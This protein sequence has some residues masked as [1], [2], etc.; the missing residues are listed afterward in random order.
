MTKRTEITIETDQVLVIRRRR[1]VLRTWCAACAEKVEMV[2]ADEAA[3]AA[4]VDLGTIHYWVK[5]CNVHFRETPE[6][7]LYVCLNSLYSLPY[8]AG[9][10]PVESDREPSCKQIGGSAE[11]VHWP[12]E[13]D[14]FQ[15]KGFQGEGFPG[16]SGSG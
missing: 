11:Q 1:K 9:T 3:V 2:T 5:A 4:S 15:G 12:P 6:G 7:L 10:S 13:G 16:H 14:G 8:D